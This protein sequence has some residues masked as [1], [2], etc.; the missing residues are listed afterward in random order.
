MKIRVF[1]EPFIGRVS[2]FISN[3]VT[4]M[5]E[6]KKKKKRKL[7][8]VAGEVWWGHKTRGRFCSL[9]WSC[10]GPRPGVAAAAAAAIVVGMSWRG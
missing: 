5:W 6:K 2:R 7:N 1:G 8:V 4:Q 3:G 9:T 10:S